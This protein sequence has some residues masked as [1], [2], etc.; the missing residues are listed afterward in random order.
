[1]KQENMKVIWAWVG[2]RN[3]KVLFAS[4]P[5][6]GMKNLPSSCL[7][8]KWNQTWAT[9]RIHGGIKQTQRCGTSAEHQKT[10]L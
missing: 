5:M 3:K 9:S 1:M 4:D 10:C 7:Q 6:G 8:K 2:G